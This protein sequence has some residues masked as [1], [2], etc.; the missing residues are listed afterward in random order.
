M[1]IIYQ[2]FLFNVFSSSCQRDRSLVSKV[3][4]MKSS[5]LSLLHVVDSIK[6]LPHPPT[7]SKQFNRREANGDLM[8][9][10]TGSTKIHANLVP[11]L[12]RMLARQSKLHISFQPQSTQARPPATNPQNT[13]HPPTTPSSAPH[14]KSN[15]SSH[16]PPPTSPPPHPNA[17]TTPS[18]TNP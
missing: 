16:S 5:L 17:P 8:L 3:D 2:F 11:N 15:T 12:R 1:M 9:I 4:G 14:P 13:S 10:S 7:P 6:C 18:Q